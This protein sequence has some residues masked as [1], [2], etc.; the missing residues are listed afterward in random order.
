M[1]KNN[2]EKSNYLINLS[3]HYDTLAFNDPSDMQ[4][5][6]GGKNECCHCTQDRLLLHSSFFEIYSKRLREKK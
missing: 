3:I 2:K 4:R 1:K 6:M 5:S